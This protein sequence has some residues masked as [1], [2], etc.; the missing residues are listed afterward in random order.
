MKDNN[1]HPADIFVDR[2]MVGASSEQHA[3]ARENVVRFV[4]VLV[5][6]DARIK[7]ERRSS[8]SPETDSCGRFEIVDTSNI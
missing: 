4:A 8:D 6:I 5:R 7:R 3:E 2:Y 1:K